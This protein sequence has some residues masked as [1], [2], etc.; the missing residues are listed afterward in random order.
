MQTAIEAWRSPLI[1]AASSTGGRTALNWTDL[2]RA[3]GAVLTD[4][5]RF[6]LLTYNPATPREPGGWHD[7]RV[8]V[9]RDDVE[10]RARRG[11][12]EPEGRS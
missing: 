6:Y 7:V 8:E 2:D 11:Y 4:T 1:D 9:T 3:I 12:R 10:V 5:A